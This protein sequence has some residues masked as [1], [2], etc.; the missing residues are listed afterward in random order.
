MVSAGTAHDQRQKS[1]V[2]AVIGRQVGRP[3]VSRICLSMSRF[4]ATADLT[5]ETAN[6]ATNRNGREGWRF[7]CW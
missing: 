6:G 1:A 7:M 2:S 3:P 5:R 4:A